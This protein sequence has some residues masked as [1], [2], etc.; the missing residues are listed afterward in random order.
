MERIERNEA[1]VLFFPVYWWSVPALAKGWIDRVWN[2]G[3]AYGAK[4][5]RHSGA[6]LLATA[7][8]GAESYSRRRYDDAMRIQL[9]AGTMNYCGIM[10]S[11]LEIFHDVT[12]SEAARTRHLDRARELGATYFAMDAFQHPSS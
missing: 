11:D 5:L 12:D 8:G 9:V 4:K 10:K 7:S 6:L 1:T 3:W 2:N